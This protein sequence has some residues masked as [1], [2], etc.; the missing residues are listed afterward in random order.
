MKKVLHVTRGYL[1]GVANNISQAVSNYYPNEFT[2]NW[3]PTSLQRDDLLNFNY[4][5]S[6]ADI[7]HWHNWVD[8]NIITSTISHK[9][10][11]V[12]YHSEP[13]NIDIIDPDILAD[14][15]PAVKQ[16]VVA[17]YHAALQYYKG[18]TP[19]RNV[20][21]IPPEW[22]DDEKM[23]YTHGRTNELKIAFSP[24]SQNFGIWQTK[25]V[26]RHF[27]LLKS[28]KEVLSKQGIKLTPVIIQNTRYDSCIW[29]KSSCDI[30][31]DEC[32]T[33][34]FHLSALEGL[35][36]GKMTFCW[37]DERVNQVIK[38]VTGADVHPFHG[39]YIGWMQDIMLDKLTRGPEYIKKQSSLAYDWFREYWNPRD[40]AANYR[41]IYNDL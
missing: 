30:V 31:L 21:W 32:V 2:F 19:I 17:Q 10:H 36:L 14:K 37:V 5:V 38:N 27:T 18:C 8:P 9:K 40:I 22:K 25:G 24:T 15:L 4:R 20:V 16:L 26:K 6:E 35:A 39:D 3:V 29:Q 34:S 33:P 23:L 12:H 28:L 1:A 41:D 11:V 7:V 13:D